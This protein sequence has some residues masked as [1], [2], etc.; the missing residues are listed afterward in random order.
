M[1]KDQKRK[2]GKPGKHHGE[3]QGRESNPVVH[4]G[5]HVPAV[6][7]LQFGPTT[8]SPELNAVQSGAGPLPSLSPHWPLSWQA[9]WQ[10]QPPGLP[11]QALGTCKPAL[12]RP[13]TPAH[14]CE[15][16]RVSVQSRTATSSRSAPVVTL[17]P[18]TEQ[19]RGAGGNNLLQFKRKELVAVQRTQ[20]CYTAKVTKQDGK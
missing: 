3:A 9:H 6:A 19:A 14:M 2:G 7:L 20:S 11:E 17:S 8:T 15:P 13:A 5:K 1:R 12:L 16:Y 18:S 10:V 4:S